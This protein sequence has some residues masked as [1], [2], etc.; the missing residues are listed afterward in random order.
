[1]STDSTKAMEEALQAA[2]QRL[3]GNGP[4]EGHDPLGV[5]GSLLP[6]LFARDED[7]RDELLEKLEGVQREDL[8]PLR[9][10]V[11]HLRKALHRAVKLQEATLAEVRAVAEQQRAVVAAVLELARHMARVQI[12]EDLPEEPGEPAVRARADART[13]PGRG[14][15][16]TRTR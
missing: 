3:N 1:M 8:A 14:A 2:A 13:E 9:E 4:R 15:P 12:I 10:E 6:R 16:G 7:E 5:L 11:L